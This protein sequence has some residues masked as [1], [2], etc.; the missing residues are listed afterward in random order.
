[1]T[2]M[3]VS[4]G[5]RLLVTVALRGWAWLVPLGCVSLAS[6]AA[7]LLLPFVVGHVVD[8]AIQE[9]GYV[10]WLAACAALVAL[11]VVAEAISTLA[12]GSAVASA[13]AR[14]RELLATHVLTVGN[15]L[16]PRPGPR[17][18]PG[19]G[20]AVPTRPPAEAAFSTGDTVS[21][22]LG[23]A[24]DAGGGPASMLTSVIAA[25]A[26]VGGLV[27]L[28][29]IDPWLVAAFAVV[30]PVLAVTLRRLARDSSQV[31]T[32]YGRV[33]GAIAARLLDALA[34]AR[35]IAA[36][37][38]QDLERQRI[39][40]PLA[41]LREHGYASWRVMARA[42]TQGGTITPALQL[43][44]VAVAGLELARH[45][46]TPGE[47]VAAIQYAAMAAGIGATAGLMARLGQA[48]G[49]ARRAAELL[50]TPAPEHGE[51]VLPSPGGV[52]GQP[53]QGELRLSGVTALRGGEKVLRNLDLTIPGGAAVALVGKSGAGKSTLAELAGRLAD[54][55]AGIVTLDGIDLRELTRV[56]LR[57]AIVYAFERP[58]LFGETPRE[59]ISFGVADPTPRQLAVAAEDAQAAAFISRL[60]GGFDASLPDTRLSGGEV[61]RLGLA[62]A[63]AHA[64]AARL[65]IL[66]DAT[67]S[68]DTVTEMLVSQALTGRL[69]DQ[70]RLIIAHRAATAARADLVA[71]LEGGKIRAIAPHEALWPDADYRGLFGC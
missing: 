4:A 6:T 66:D 69:R 67:S 28:G 63:F 54:P 5:D 37:G 9:T 35:T 40:A 2:R 55:D 34:G 38:T 20:S 43:I 24:A 42:A 21:R 41:E 59:A 13:T 64:S 44:V 10:G 71:W 70:T 31:S 53:L 22:I 19:R 17:A 12:G 51:V 45:R 18:V 3:T 29:L 68:L 58:H 26:P 61:Q 62:R 16:T 36:A 8:A 56:S 30:F 14:V 33:Q 39:L 48:R 11:I 47:L 32:D 1:M 46:I 15:R 23:S 27:A 52:P 50:T 57:T 65:V 7:G 49:G 25:T 60:P